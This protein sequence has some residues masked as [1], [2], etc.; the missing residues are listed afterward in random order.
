MVPRRCACSGRS[1]VG[2]RGSGS[3]LDVLVDMERQGLLDHAALKGDLED[4]LGCAVH[5]TTKGGLRY[6]REQ[7][8]ERIEREA[9]RL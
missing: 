9:V 6:A 5:V 7:T 3:H 8:R 4:L 2:T 1:L